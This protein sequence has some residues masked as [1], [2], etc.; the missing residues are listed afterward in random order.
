MLTQ[1]RKTKTQITKK[2]A[3]AIEKQSD[4]DVLESYPHLTDLKLKYRNNDLDKIDLTIL[5]TLRSLKTL[6]LSFHHNVIGADYRL[7]NIDL[8][9]LQACYELKKF[10]LGFDGSFDKVT[11]EPLKN[12]NLERVS[13][14]VRKNV[15]DLTHI[16][17]KTLKELTVVG[18]RIKR[19]SLSPLKKCTSLQS[20]RIKTNNI[21][22]II[23]KPLSGLKELK[24]L[25]LSGNSLDVIDISPLSGC[26]SLETL[27]LSYNDIPKV[28]LT[29]LRQLD[30]LRNVDL[31]YCLGSREG[32]QIDI[33][34]VL[35]NPS[36]TNLDLTI[37]SG[38]HLKIVADPIHRFTDKLF[39]CKYG[40]VPIYEHTSYYDFKRSIKRNGWSK[41]ITQMKPYIA[42]TLREDWFEMS[43]WILKNF[44][45]QNIAG[46]EGHPKEI[47][48]TLPDEEEI[49]YNEARNIILKQMIDL[50]KE[51]F[52]SGGGTFNINVESKVMLET[53]AS[54]L[55]KDILTLRKREDFFVIINRWG[56]ADPTPLWCTYYGRK[57]L[58]AGKF[59]LDLYRSKADY[60][61]HIRE[62]GTR[63]IIDR[64]L[65]DDRIDELANIVKETT[66]KELKIINLKKGIRNHPKYLQEMY[67]RY[68]K[69]IGPQKEPVRERKKRER[70]KRIAT[71]NRI[72]RRGIS[73]C[74]YCKK[75]RNV[76]VSDYAGQKTLVIDCP[77][78][79]T[80]NIVAFWPD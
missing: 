19:I 11:A 17:S 15:V 52:Q 30:N 23:L 18:G 20:L 48:S 57:I 69:K 29:P 13:I 73:R 4:L 3:L 34:P 62:Q 46:Y 64:L 61:P 31:S 14:S 27:N 50:L 47:L 2:K 37:Y 6:R 63:E 56:L 35:D 80:G 78:C 60:S 67:K 51:Q 49:T 79:G 55:I 5:S 42:D 77:R 71:F 38:R 44:R 45:L 76:R 26:K 28:I 75:M 72:L 41:F 12:L 54:N 43:S 65:D 39:I 40:D 70:L 7:V 8:S 53:P 1:K 33:T 32:V 24:R 21:S 66:G 36:V 10:E 59:L 9:P 25:D 74:R 68:K 22:K 16:A 58:K